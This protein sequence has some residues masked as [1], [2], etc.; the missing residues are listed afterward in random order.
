MKIYDRILNIAIAT[1]EK[2]QED[3][4]FLDWDV[5]FFLSLANFV[6][7]RNYD[8]TYYLVAEE[9]AQYV[10]NDVKPSFRMRTE[11]LGRKLDNASLLK[12]W[13]IYVRDKEGK[14]VHKTGW[15]INVTRLN[16]RVAKY[17]KI[18]PAVEEPE[19]E[20]KEKP[21]EVFEEDA[22]E[23]LSEEERRKRLAEVG[24][25]T[26]WRKTRNRRP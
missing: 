2:R 7:T 6:S 8:G 3:A 19:K 1:T 18:F 11:G 5:K 10:I 12:R 23:N 16:H 4:F 24:R 17:R 26:N 13:P 15:M 14:L 20:E 25:P 9:V 22:W 21:T